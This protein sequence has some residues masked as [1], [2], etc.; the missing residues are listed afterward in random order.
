ML[1]E[2]PALLLRPLGS[3]ECEGRTADQEVLLV[4]RELHARELVIEVATQDHL[5]SAPDVA[6]PSGDGFS[7]ALNFE[8]G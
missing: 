1:L 4:L 6:S 7:G 5:A 3:V 2:K 8:A